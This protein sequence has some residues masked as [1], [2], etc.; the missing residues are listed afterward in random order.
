MSDVG[1]HQNFIDELPRISKNVFE[2][3]FK[4]HKQTD[5]LYYYNLLRTMHFPDELDRK[6]FYT[7]NITSPEPLTNLSFKFYGDIELW[8]LICLANKIDN[9]VELIPGGTTIRVV[10]AKYIENIINK[11]KD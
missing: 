11:L 3:L 6:Y 1:D 9:P 4:V 10:R 7:Y 8:W 5:G 2:N